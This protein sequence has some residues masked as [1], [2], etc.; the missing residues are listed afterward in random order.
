MDL[1]KLADIIGTKA[2][3]KSVDSGAPGKEWAGPLG[4]AYGIWIISTYIY[5]YIHIHA[6]IYLIY[7]YNYIY[8]YVHMHIHIFDRRIRSQTSDNMDR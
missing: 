4:C 1:N 8:M 5:I 2:K 7:I 6:Y 3:A